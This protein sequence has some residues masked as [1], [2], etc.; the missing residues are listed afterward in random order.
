MRS[1]V[2]FK[3]NEKNGVLME[4]NQIIHFLCNWADI[5]IRTVSIFEI[6][7]EKESFRIFFKTN[8]EKRHNLT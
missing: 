2:I 4:I 1:D 8:K 5:G 6:V 7:F 3:E